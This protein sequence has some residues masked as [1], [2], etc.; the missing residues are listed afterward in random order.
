MLRYI[1]IKQYRFRS[2][3]AQVPCQYIYMSISKDYFHC[4]LSIMSYIA[5]ATCGFH[6]PYVRTTAMYVYSLSVFIDKCFQLL[7]L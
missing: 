7:L 5:L 3:A 6:G 4:F 2:T 1:A